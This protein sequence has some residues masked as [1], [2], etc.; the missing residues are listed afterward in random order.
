MPSL[1]RCPTASSPWSSWRAARATGYPLA[2]VIVNSPLCSVIPT[3]GCQF[4][5]LVFLDADGDGIQDGDDDCPYIANPDGEDV[6]SGYGC[7]DACEQAQLHS[8]A[9]AGVPSQPTSSA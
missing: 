9:T 2:T 4:N 6:C 3:M 8:L 1:G 5:A 7:C